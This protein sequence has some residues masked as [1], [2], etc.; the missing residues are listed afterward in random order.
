MSM[1]ASDYSVIPLCADCHQFAP[2]SY[3]RIAGGRRG[4][5]R[6]RLGGETCAKIAARLRAEWRGRAK[7][8]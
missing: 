1:K 3:H 6:V 2:D 7:A 5:E 8:S 4:F